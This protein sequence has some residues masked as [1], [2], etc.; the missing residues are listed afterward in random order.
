MQMADQLLAAV[1]VLDLSGGTADTVARLLA[2]LGAD[3]LKVEPPGGS[4]GRNQAPTLAGA[5]IPFAVH[6]ANKRSVVL[7][8]NDAADR[9][10]LLELAA[11]ADILVDSGLPGRPAATGH[12]VWS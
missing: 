1:R 2:D 12:R 3:V 8:P 9:A 10:R 5:S 4:P 7:D 6:N 11:G